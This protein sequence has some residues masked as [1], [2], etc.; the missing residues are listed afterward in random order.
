MRSK[1]SNKQAINIPSPVKIIKGI[2]LDNQFYKNVR[3]ENINNY[4]FQFC[5][6][7]PKTERASCEQQ[8][9]YLITLR[10][11]RSSLPF[12]IDGSGFHIDALQ[13]EKLGGS[14]QRQYSN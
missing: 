6:F 3:I 12:S 13:Y 7:Y 11:W 9:G 10:R 14:T 8:E 2:T 5:L 4:F 1:L